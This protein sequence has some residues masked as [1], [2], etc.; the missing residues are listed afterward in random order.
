MKS[1][2]NTIAG[3]I[4]SLANVPL[5][6]ES[7]LPFSI[8]LWTPSAATR[9]FMENS[10]F[11]ITMNYNGGMILS[12]GKGQC[13]TRTSPIIEA[14]LFDNGYCYF[15]TEEGYKYQ[16][17]SYTMIED[18][19]LE[20]EISKL[21][22]KIPQSKGA[23]SR[24]EINGK[25]WLA[26]DRVAAEYKIYSK[27]KGGAKKVASLPFYTSTETIIRVLNCFQ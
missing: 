11:F 8:G 1:I 22:E 16:F 9:V 18:K 3:T 5:T 19:H 7:H 24:I 15:V 23:E 6:L 10:P 4:T 25:L 26:F 2:I 13:M 17:V 20:D 27:E 21:I 14:K 12:N